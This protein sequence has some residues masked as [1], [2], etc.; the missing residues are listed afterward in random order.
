MVFP[1]RV[2]NGNNCIRRDLLEEVS[3]DFQCA[4]T[5]DRLGGDDATGCQQWRIGAEQQRLHS[6]VVS[7]DAV[8]RQVAA[9]G[10]LGSTGGLGFDHCAQQWNTP[11]FVAV[12]TDPQVDFVGAG[13]GVECFVEAQD[14]IAW[15]Q[16]DSGKQAHFYRSSEWRIKR[17]AL[18]S[19]PM[20]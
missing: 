18:R 8:D 4:S 14:G 16:F 5:A 9:R 11:F 20:H 3:T 7:H 15:C 6:L 17:A 2:A 19:R 10:V 13:I 12:N 1:A